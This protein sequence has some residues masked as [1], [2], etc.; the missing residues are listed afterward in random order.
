M[1]PDP[2]HAQLLSIVGVCVNRIGKVPSLHLNKITQHSNALE[3]E[4]I[5]LGEK[6]KVSYPVPPGLRLRYEDECWHLQNDEGARF[7]PITQ[8]MM[9]TMYYR[10][11]C[12]NFHLQYIGQAFGE[13]GDRNIIE[14]L[15]SHEILQKISL[16]G[17]PEGYRLEIVLVEVHPDTRFVTIFSPIDEDPEITGQ[18][19]ANGTDKLFNTTEQE[20]IALY[21]ACL[22]RYFRPKFNIKLKDSF[23]STRIK[24]LKDCYDKDFLA[25]IAEFCFDEFPYMLCSEDIQPSESH[26]AH[27]NLQTK[28]DRELFFSP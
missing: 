21:E 26:I 7:M 5:V 10:L 1:G 2:L 9:M 22:I 23:P 8:D 16:Q 19:I 18:R 24:I 13:N 20:R 3:Y 11:E 15:R 12:P 6:R 17:V 27:F 28:E 4:F 25:I 14:R